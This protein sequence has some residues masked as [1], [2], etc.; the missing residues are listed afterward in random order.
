M[1]VLRVGLRR[2]SRVRRF[3][4]A[5]TSNLSEIQ[6]EFT[7]QSTGFESAWTARNTQSTE[8]I[9]AKVLRQV[10]LQA[11]P[12][13]STSRALDVAT[14]T[15]I[16][17]RT[18][19]P[20]CAK[21]TGLDA[22]EAM[23][24]QARKAVS[25]LPNSDAID[26]ITGDAGAMP[27]ADNSFDLVVS[28]LAIHHFPEPE[29]QAKEIARVTRPGGRAILVDLVSPDDPDA[30]SSLNHLETL[31]DPSHTTSLTL[32]SLRDLLSKQGFD[33]KVGDDEEAFGLI[34]NVMDFEGW[35]ESTS[36]DAEH[37]TVIRER[38]EKELDGTGPATGMYP[39]VDESDGKIKFVHKWAV[40]QGLVPE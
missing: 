21:V 13:D 16:F 39:F 25:S 33:V 32:S 9:M 22:T 2:C 37:R 18:I 15:G 4:S 28:R 7:R 30:A 8:S 6:S 27:F 11:G 14:G 31:R 5:S 1:N 34:D 26:F 23:L 24:D 3:S 20:L 38:I 29:A 35:M 10:E 36:T 17:A 19:L 40:V 12:I